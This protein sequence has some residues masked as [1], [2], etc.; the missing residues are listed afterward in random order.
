MLW[1]HFLIFAHFW[2]EVMFHASKTKVILFKFVWL[3]VWQIYKGRVD[4]CFFCKVESFDKNCEYFAVFHHLLLSSSQAV[5][6]SRLCLSLIVGALSN[7]QRFLF[8]KEELIFTCQSSLDFLSP[9]A[10][11]RQPDRQFKFVLDFS[12]LLFLLSIWSFSS[13]SFLSVC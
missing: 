7:F 10:H 13:Q 3:L 8:L 12:D 4:K 6:G 11:I 1:I 5:L 9:S 2:G